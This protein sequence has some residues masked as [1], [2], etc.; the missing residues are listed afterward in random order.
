MSIQDIAAKFVTHL[1]ERG[2]A[3]TLRVAC[4]R[5]WRI[6]FPLKATVHPF[7]TAHGVDTSGL[8]SRRHLRSDHV[9][10]RFNTAYWGVAPSLFR[11]ALAHWEDSLGALPAHLSDFVFLDL[12]SG[13]G[14]A[15]MLA[16]DFPFT[17]IVGL[18]LSP[19]LAQIAQ[20]NLAIWL[21]APHLCDQVEVICTDAF[22]YPLP[23]DPLLIYLFN[24]FTA[25]LVK[26]LVERLRLLRASQSSPIDVIYVSPFHAAAFDQYPEVQ[27]L[28]DGN[29]PFSSADAAADIFRNPGEH[30]RIYRIN[31]PAEASERPGLS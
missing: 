20:G 21:A 16:S 27:L 11:T 13:K 5:I 19:K 30:C 31:Q 15:L 10:D 8:I 2:P 12:G 14:R 23:D 17:R 1:K 18:E 26:L 4:E 22:E 7:D 6:V 28:W 29:I 25:P 3:E 9:H 24:S